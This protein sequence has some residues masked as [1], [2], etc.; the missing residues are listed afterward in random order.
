MMKKPLWV[1]FGIA[2]L[3]LLAACTEKA[4]DTDVDAALPDDS[5]GV[6]EMLGDDELIDQTDLS[7]QPDQIVVDDIMVDDNA[8]DDLSDADPL[9]VDETPDELPD[10]DADTGP[11]MPV[12]PKREQHG[13]WTIVWLSGTP[14]EMGFQQ[15]QL[16]HDQIENGIKNSQYVKDINGQIQIATL[17][18]VD[19]FAELN[20]Y[21]DIVQE[22]E[23]MVAAAGDVGWSMELCLF[24]NF[25]DVMVEILDKLPFA[26]RAPRPGCSQMMVTGDATADGRTYHGRILDWAEID[27]LLWYP[28]ILV[29]QPIDGLPH[30]FIGFPG[31]LSPY[32]GMNVAGLSMASNESDGVDG[33]QSD[34]S[35]RSHVQMMGQMLKRSAS[36]DEAIAFM[37]GE[38]HMSVEQIGIADA[39]LGRA[40][41][42][43]MTAKKTAVRE[44]TEGV[45]WMTNHFVH[46]DMEA[47]DLDPAGESSLRRFTRFS[48]LLPPDGTE[49]R[50]G[51]FDPP[52][53]VR[54][55][56]DRINANS[57]KESPLGTF[58][59]NRSLATNGAIY[60]MVFD[61]GSLH[62]W[63]AAGTIP[64]PEQEFTGFSLGTL[65][66]W[67]G[68]T[69]VDPAVLP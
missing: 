47:L 24:I 11:W 42:F 9:L 33:S 67:P 31:N 7:D 51:T 4:A 27:F 58:D 36:L 56:R 64:V 44:M 43:E 5:A 39:N 54:V 28:T 2:V 10:V 35:G 26:A 29:R 62:F 18:Q 52:E 63:A 55:L 20:S 21:P 66:N 13:I 38:N 37:Q 12:L 46:P 25:G 15:G 60:A 49:S 23:G 53:V 45:L 1:L 34:Y 65:L 19:K 59:D 32:S 22:C 41:V 48:Q 6:D 57:G 8:A 30:V 69:P 68:A 61:P 16:L 17:A 40:G 50:Y 3:L 14:Y